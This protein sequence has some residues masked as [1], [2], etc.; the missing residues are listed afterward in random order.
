[1]APALPMWWT[2]PK[3]SLASPQCKEE[4]T[5]LG[6]LD[7]SW[8]SR[9]LS[10]E[11]SHLGPALGAHGCQLTTPSLP[12]DQ[13]PTR[14]E[15]LSTYSRLSIPGPMLQVRKLRPRKETR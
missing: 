3:G 13:A 10:S 14:G 2:G 6:P 11:S 7:Q 1:M 9:T 12:T 8:H 5:N 15:L 4:I